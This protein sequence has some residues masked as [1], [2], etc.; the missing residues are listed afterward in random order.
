MASE[1]EQGK[2]AR[3]LLV[4]GL[5]GT[6]LG[7][8]LSTLYALLTKAAEAKELPPDEK[9]NYLLECLTGLV[10]VLAQVAERQA[11]LI[12]LMEQWLAAQGVPPGE[13]I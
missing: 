10:A 11:G 4:G 5:G 8:A 13:G 3:D 1:R 2:T 9:F 6:A 7:V 12:T